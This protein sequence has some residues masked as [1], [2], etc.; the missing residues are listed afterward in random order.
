MARTNIKASVHPFSVGDKVW[1][2]AVKQE[3]RY[4]LTP[5]KSYTV[6]RVRDDGVR[7]EVR[8]DDDRLLICKIVGDARL[9]DMVVW[10]KGS[11]PPTD[12]SKILAATRK[13]KRKIKL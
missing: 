8:G 7:F 4:R 11:P 13:R 10:N 9:P 2:K 1:V 12:A 3:W 5:R 6:T